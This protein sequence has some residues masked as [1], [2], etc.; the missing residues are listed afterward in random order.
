VNKFGC[1]NLGFGIGL[2]TDHYPDFLNGHPNVDFLEIISEGFMIEGGRP[3]HILDQL[4]DRYPIIPHGVSLSIGSIDPL[5]ESYLTRLKGLLDKINPPWFSDHICWT[6]VHGK[7][8]HNLMPLPYTQSTVDFVADKIKQLQDRMGRLFIFENVSSYVEF[9]QSQMPEWEF[10]AKVAQQA[11]CGILLDVNNIFVSSFN[12]DFDPMDYINA[13][14]ADRIIQYHVA[15]HKDKGSVIIDTHD[16]TIRDEVWELYRK[17]T[18]IFDGVSTLLERDDH[19]PEIN[20]LLSE[21]DTA[22]KL[23]TNVPIPS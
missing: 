4:R 10:V 22:R 11:D 6:K 18:T 8:L 5:D 3:L 15:G 1:P 17:C 14:P 7:N 12:H 19:I 16:H 9:Q 23:N 21:L 2:R 20:D 13:M